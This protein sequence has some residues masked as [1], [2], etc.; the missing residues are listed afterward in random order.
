MN[1]FFLDIDPKKCAEYHCDK[2]VVKMIIEIVQ[3]L[4]CAHHAVKSKL[5]SDCYKQTHLNHPICV[6]I[7]KNVQNY[8]YSAQVALELAKEYTYRYSKIHSSQKHVEWLII[9]IPKFEN[10]DYSKKVILSTNITF[11]KNGMTPVPLAMPED[12][13][14]NDTV[15]SYRNYYLKKKFARWTSRPVPDWFCFINVFN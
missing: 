10:V 4:Y 11:L 8:T 2:H 7:R 12:S 5:P 1:L 15:K 3:M 6:W 13:M 9:N 14:L